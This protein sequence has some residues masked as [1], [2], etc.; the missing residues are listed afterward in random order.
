MQHVNKLSLSTLTHGSTDVFEFKA[1]A[2]NGWFSSLLL[3]FAHYLTLRLNGL[4]DRQLNSRANFKL[5]TAHSETKRM[6]QN[7]NNMVSHT[8]LQENK[9][10]Y[11]LPTN[12]SILNHAS[13]T[14]T[15]AMQIVCLW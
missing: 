4:S 2:L 14:A 9:N 1:S 11:L 6:L 13:L 5:N 8:Q 15:Y 3:L 12:P 10:R 7:R